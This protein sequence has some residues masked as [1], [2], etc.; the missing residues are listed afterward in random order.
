MLETF[1]KLLLPFSVE[2]GMKLWEVERECCRR[3]GEGAAGEVESALQGQAASPFR[4]GGR[5]KS[6]PVGR[7]LG[8]THVPFPHREV[9]PLL[10]LLFL[11]KNATTE[12]T[13]GSH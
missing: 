6:V 8:G 9:H 10:G 7:P 12:W 13:C 5:R 11:V 1:L 4:S 3:G 2:K